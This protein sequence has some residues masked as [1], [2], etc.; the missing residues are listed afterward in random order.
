MF[1]PCMRISKS[2]AQAEPGVICIGKKIGTC[3]G[4]KEHFLD[5][6]QSLQ[7]ARH[8]SEKSQ[9]RIQCNEM[10]SITYRANVQF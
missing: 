4:I 6:S 9:T 2:K 10:T 5:S 1:V 3:T 7:A 8:S